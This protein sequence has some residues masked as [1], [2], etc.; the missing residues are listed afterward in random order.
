MLGSD[1]G[2]VVEERAVILKRVQVVVP[3]AFNQEQLLLAGNRF[4]QFLAVC[5]RDQLIFGA[6]D[7]HNRAGDVSDLF[8]VVEIE[9]QV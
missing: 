2:E 8:E 3:T 1:G 4:H 9:A 5:R 7:E 6:M